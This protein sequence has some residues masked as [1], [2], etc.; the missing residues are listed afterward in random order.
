MLF[1]TMQSGDFWTLFDIFTGPNPNLGLCALLL[2]SGGF[3][4]VI[5]MNILLVVTIC[6]PVAL[7]VA[8]TSKDIILTFVGIAIF[9][10]QKLSAPFLIG[11]ALSFSGAGL[12]TWGK[13][14]AKNE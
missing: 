2:V 8:G 1:L 3:G 9:Q 14:A 10:D 11:L 7:N 5:T 13:V 4:F 12:F 6:G